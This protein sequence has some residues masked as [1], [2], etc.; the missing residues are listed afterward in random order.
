MRKNWTTS[1]KSLA[2]FE[3]EAATRLEL[4]S[5]KAN[6]YAQRYGKDAKSG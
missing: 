6:Y 4:R 2:Q 3:K 1:R 5:M